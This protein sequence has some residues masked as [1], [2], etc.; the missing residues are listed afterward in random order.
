MKRG[1]IRKFGRIKKQ[2]EALTRSLTSALILHGRIKTTQARAKTLRSV[3]EKFVT[4]AKKQNISARRLIAQQLHAR[5]AHKLM[6]EW[7]PKFANRTG[8]YTRII[9]L[10][11][12]R[13]DGSPM[14]LV[15]F[16]Q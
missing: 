8:G 1:T 14:A 16:V 6:Q 9:R 13:S 10:P 3:A 4:L 7:A 11:Q 5:V 12:R 2:R 15:E